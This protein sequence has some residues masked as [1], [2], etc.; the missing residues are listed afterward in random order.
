M[1]VELALAAAI[2]WRAPRKGLL[3]FLPALALPIAAFFATNYAAIGMWRP[4]YSEF[5]GPWYQ[6]E[7][8]HWKPDPLKPKRG[9]DWAGL[10]EDKATYA[11]HLLVGHHGV[12]SLSPLF[13]L[14]LAGMGWGAYQWLTRPRRPS[15]PEDRTLP[16]P[17]R[18][19]QSLFAIATLLLSV[20]V[21]GFYI[22]QSNNYGGWT[23]APRWLIWLIPLWLLTLL[24]IADRLASRRTGRI[25]A[26][27]FLAIS[28]VSASYSPWSP[29]RHPWLYN[30]LEALKV[31]D[32]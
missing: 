31:I 9:I 6:Y 27:I 8:S 2:L 15:A 20:V 21:V 23:M 25:M 14:S 12:F 7:G 22:Y 11:F 26:Y 17:T 19:F 13:L 24:P 16:D 10:T 32:Y 29:W 4:A 1:L 5:G 28:V 18:L 3:L 30:W